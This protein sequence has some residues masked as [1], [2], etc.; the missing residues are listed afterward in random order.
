[1]FPSLFR[2][3]GIAALCGG[4]L[5]NTA[6]ANDDAEINRLFHA[7][8]VS[9]AFSRLDRLLVERPKD[10]GLRFL[11]AVLLADS[12]R[13]SE[14]QTIYLQLTHD[15]PE[16]PEPH[17]NLAVL[18]AAQGDYARAR[19]ALEAAL[20]ASPDYAVAH[21]NLGDVYVALAQ[22]SYTDAQRLDATNAAIA[23]KL[24]ALRQI[25]ARIPS[26]PASQ[27]TP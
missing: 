8:Q 2:I 21:H 7:G 11:K 20:R 5:V 12:G 24:A 23:P 25:T 26:P 18:H 16:L 4:V 22:H 19:S 6:Q 15:Y 17:N 14:A 27:G 10:P 1:M 9:E 3:V 13:R